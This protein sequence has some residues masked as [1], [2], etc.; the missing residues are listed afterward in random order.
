MPVRTRTNL[1]ILIALLALV[2]ACGGTAVAAQ[3]AKNSVTSKSIKN[4][5][6]KSK[7][8]KDGSVE[9][10]DVADGS[11]GSGDVAN[12]SLGSADVEDGSLGSADLTNGSIASVDVADNGL[13]GTDIVEGT[14]GTVPN[15]TAVGG[16]QVSPLSVSLPSTSPGVQVLSE[17]GDSVVLDCEGA[18]L[19]Y[20]LVR[21][22]SGAPLLYS[23][24]LSSGGSTGASLD[25][26]ENV[27]IQISEG[28]FTISMVLPSGGSVTLEFSGLFE[29]NASGTN[30]CF[31]RGTVTRTP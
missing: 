10:V 29:T 26:S 30:D 5:A 4:N 24:I 28:H 25:P 18:A 16:V 20:V 12:G 31:F 15:A 6:V 11:L 17:S 21:G 23:G 9:S 2:I 22:A 3:V 14:L 1:A 8:L 19:R 13:T 27:E 7:D